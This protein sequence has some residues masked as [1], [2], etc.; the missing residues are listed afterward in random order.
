MALFRLMMVGDVVGEN[1]VA[2]V[3]ELLPS[4]IAEHN[5]DF[6]VVNGEN[7]HE[8]RGINETI[9]K[10]LYKAGADVVT[11]GDHSFDKHLIF[12]YMARDRRLL[13]P[14]NYPKGAPGHGYCIVEKKGVT[15]GVMNLRGQSY[16]QNPIYCPFHTADRFLPELRDKASIVFVDFHAEATAEK[17]A[18]A[19]YLDG[20]VGAVCGTHTHVQ[21]ADECILPK[22]TG[23]LT[24]VG[25][26]GPTDS[27]IGMD[28]ETA[29][30]R[31]LL[32]IPQ[33]YKLAE[34]DVYLCAAIFAI[35]TLTGTTHSIQR[36]RVHAP[37]ASKIKFGTPQT[38]P[39]TPPTD[40]IA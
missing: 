32:Q 19:R 16:F 35:D 14:L 5:V 40:A 18:L 1:G 28:V 25:F 34:G 31:A 38:E 26:T 7:A 23:F 6:C 11:G 37:E 21:T 33:K 15:V 27:V 29:I 20:R 8:G 4:L 36:L 2:A 24:D 10:K 30:N 17:A 9:V 3:K 12:P 39:E 13:R 22:G